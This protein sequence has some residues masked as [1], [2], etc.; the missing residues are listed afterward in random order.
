MHERPRWTPT[1]ENNI[2][3]I[4]RDVYYRRNPDHRLGRPFLTA[5]QLAIEYDERFPELLEQCGWPIGGRGVGVRD[6][7]AKW[8]ARN[9]ARCIRNGEIED[10]EGGFL[11]DLH[12]ACITFEGPD[13]II[14]PSVEDISTFRFVESD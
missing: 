5:Y 2:R 11:S 4:L 8:L 1:V 13:G 14:R 12:L 3:E 9:L 6:S 7:L 10:I